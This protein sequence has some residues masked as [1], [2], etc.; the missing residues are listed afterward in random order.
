V[1]SVWQMLLVLS[2]MGK[3]S[4]DDM[5]VAAEIFDRF[6]AS[7]TRRGKI[8]LEDMQKVLV[9]ARR[10]EGHLERRYLYVVFVV[11]V[12]TVLMYCVYILHV[13]VVYVSRFMCFYYD[14][15]SRSSS[16]TGEQSSRGGGVAKGVGNPLHDAS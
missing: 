16:V 1:F 14:V 15:Y 2:M 9:Q 6:D 11:C 4:T 7:G 3:V 5:V 12:D 10:R 13:Y 8:T